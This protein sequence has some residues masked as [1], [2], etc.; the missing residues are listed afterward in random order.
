MQRLPCPHNTA[1]LLASYAV[2][3]ELG[4]YR[5]AENPPSYLSEFCFISNQ[6]QGFEKEV[7]KHHQQHSGLNPAE[8]ELNYLNTARTLELYGVEL[9]YAR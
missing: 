8:S 5:E 2:Q 9:H 4:D 3:S 6:P 7:A 1:A